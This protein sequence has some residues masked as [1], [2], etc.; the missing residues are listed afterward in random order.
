MI[1]DDYFERFTSQKYQ[2]R[3]PVQRRLI[4][5]FVSHFHALFVAAL[6]AKKVCEIGIG[7]GFLSGYLSERFP[8]THFLG[9]D[10]EGPDLE[11]LRKNFPRI[12]TH[13]ADAQELSVLKAHTDIDLVICAEVL[14]HLPPD[15]VPGVLAEAARVLKPGGWMVA[16]TPNLAAWEN[17]EMLW[18]GHSPQQT[19]ALV[20]DGTYG[21]LRLYTME[22]LVVLFQSAGFL[23]DRRVYADQIPVG[24]SAIRRLLRLLLW[25]VRR[26]RPALRDTCLVRAVRNGTQENAPA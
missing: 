24:I 9:V 23:V 21:H 13:L 8:E 10:L 11:Q 18:R 14:E 3:N 19:A 15:T 22:E 5:R 2:N 26:I 7:Q 17:R 1:P 16:T 12:E 20:I 4:R 25:P 6:P